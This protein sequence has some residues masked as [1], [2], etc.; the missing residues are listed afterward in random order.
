MRLLGGSLS[1]GQFILNNY[2]QALQIIDRNEQ[3][4][5]GLEA[6]SPLDVN[7]AEFPHLLREEQQYLESRHE[8]TKEDDRD[9]EYLERLLKLRIA[10]YVVLSMT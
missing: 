5:A 3:L 8:R 9:V 1:K 6:S 4:L 10:E 2:R 7:R